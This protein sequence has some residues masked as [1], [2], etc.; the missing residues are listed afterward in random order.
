MTWSKLKV[1]SFCD[2]FSVKLI[3]LAGS[4]ILSIIRDIVPFA[5]VISG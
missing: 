4:V 2:E 3:R 5:G 1:C